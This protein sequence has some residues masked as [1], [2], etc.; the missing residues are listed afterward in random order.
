VPQAVSLWSVLLTSYHGIADEICQFSRQLD[1]DQAI[2]DSGQVWMESSK[3]FV[4]VV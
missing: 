1:Y 4:S 2:S 3:A